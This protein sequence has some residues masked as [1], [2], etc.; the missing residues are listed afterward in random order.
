MSR[1]H[2]ANTPDACLGPS[3]TSAHCGHGASG[4]Y[5]SSCRTGSALNG[6]RVAALLRER[7]RLARE[8][9]AIDEQMAA[10][11]DEEPPARQSKPPITDIDKAR[12]RKALRKAG[13]DV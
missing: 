4:S 13:L 1:V 11:L 5:D 9:A 10:V 7:A 2:R 8:V 3:A 12:A 6:R